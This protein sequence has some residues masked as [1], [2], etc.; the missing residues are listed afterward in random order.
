MIGASGS[1]HLNSRRRGS[2]PNVSP[3]LLH[4]NRNA[5]SLSTQH[6]EDEGMLMPELPPGV[7]LNRRRAVDTS[8]HKTCA[9]LHTRLKGLKLEDVAFLSMTQEIY[10]PT[11]LILNS[12]LL[13]VNH[14]SISHHRPMS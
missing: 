1:R 3:H 4:L 5:Q 13:W 8:D 11:K 14:K 6:E 12:R 10:S 7:R 2:S 9:L